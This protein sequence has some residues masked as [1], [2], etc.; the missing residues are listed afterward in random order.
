MTQDAP[1]D[2]R[3][4]LASIYKDIGK[5]KDR[6]TKNLVW[7]SYFDTDDPSVSS[8]LTLTSPEF[9]A[10]FLRYWVPRLTVLPDVISLD[11]L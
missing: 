2:D 9:L 8:H 6:D 1:I 4:R 11:S 5:P 10:P 7:G 3:A